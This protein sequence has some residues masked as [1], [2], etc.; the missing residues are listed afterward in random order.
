MAIRIPIRIYKVTSFNNSNDTEVASSVTSQ[1]TVVNATFSYL[2][3]VTSYD[4]QY[5]GSNAGV[6]PNINDTSVIGTIRLT[7]DNV[8][9]NIATDYT[10]PFTVK[11]DA[12]AML[13]VII[14]QRKY[15]IINTANSTDY[16]TINVSDFF[17]FY[18]N[19]QHIVPSYKKLN[20]EIRT[21]GGWEIQHFGE[22]LTELTVKGKTGGL[23]RNSALPINPGNRTSA[24]KGIVAQTLSKYQSITQSTAW[25]KLNQLKALYHADHSIA[26]TT[27]DF[28]IGF[29]YYDVFYIGYF[30]EFTG[31]EADADSPFLMDYSFSLKVEAEVSLGSVTI[32]NSNSA[33][34]AGTIK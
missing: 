12:N 24:T 11:V 9:S 18:V 30:T 15:Y 33:S 2:Q 4:I 3:G 1:D 25:I 34:I 21:R 10:K 27:S 16:T 22:N 14:A 26:N 17:E 23:Q 8:P 29:N 28:K 6:S 7:A 32:D 31:P 5:Y 13:Y 19:P 20:T